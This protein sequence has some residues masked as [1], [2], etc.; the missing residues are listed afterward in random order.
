LVAF[1]ITLIPLLLEQLSESAKLLPKWIDSGS[2]ELQ[3]LNWAASEDLPVNLRHLV[4]QLTERLPDE[5]QS[6]AEQLVNV[7]LETIDSVSEVVLTVVLAVYLLLEERLWNGLFKRLP[8][9]F[10]FFTVQQSPAELSKLL[11]GQV[12]LAF[13]CRFINDPGIFS[14]RVPF[15]LL[16]G[17]GVGL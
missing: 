6:L 10:S 14:I 17:L 4:T 16:F 1:G 9:A 5:L 12:A 7:A 2:Q 13:S 3:A 11:L 8:L 15:G